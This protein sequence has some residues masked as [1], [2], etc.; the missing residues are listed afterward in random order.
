MCF[1]KTV[2]TTLFFLVATLV[3]AKSAP[4]FDE[5]FDAIDDLDEIKLQK[6]IEN[7]ADINEKNEDGCT[8]LHYCVLRDVGDYTDDDIKKVKL[9]LKYGSYPNTPDNRGK[10]PLHIAVEELSYNGSIEIVKLLVEVGA[11]VNAK[12]NDWATPLFYA[13]DSFS[14][15]GISFL[16]NKGA[17]V[18]E[19]NGFGQTLLHRAVGMTIESEVVALLLKHGANKNIRDDKNETPLE[20][21]ERIFEELSQNLKDDEFFW[22]QGNFEEIIS[23]LKGEG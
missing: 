4:C 21:T 23:V 12:D 15:E 16:I 5:I 2:Y 13:V 14:R 22:G 11:N 1:K 18:N 6:L 10:T 8:N 17:N 7:G 20:M 9:L 3:S 19:K